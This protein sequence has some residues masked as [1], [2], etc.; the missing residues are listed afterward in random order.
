[1]GGGVERQAVRTLPSACRT[2]A[3]SSVLDGMEGGGAFPG[4][5]AAFLL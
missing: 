4:M 1:M 3:R 2:Q 5:E